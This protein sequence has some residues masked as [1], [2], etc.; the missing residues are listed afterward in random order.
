MKSPGKLPG[1]L[2]C[3][4]AVRS[5]ADSQPASSGLRAAITPD[6]QRGILMHIADLKR[7]PAARIAEIESKSA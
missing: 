3:V 1:L 7:I 2:L 4:L 5:G 6:W